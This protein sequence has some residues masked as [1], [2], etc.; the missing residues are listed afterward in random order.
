MSKFS[1]LNGIYMSGRVYDIFISYSR[2]DKWL[3]ADIC[4]SLRQAGLTVAFDED[5]LGNGD[6][7]GLSVLNIIESAKCVLFLC[8]PNSVQSNWVKNEINYCVG[9]GKRVVPV[10]LDRTELPVD[11]MSLLGALN[12]IPLNTDNLESDIAWLVNLV[13][14]F[15]KLI[16]CIHIMH[17]IRQKAFA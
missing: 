17:T 15:Q 8:T 13:R 9:I 12:V 16:Y 2:E 3:A 11:L 1:G 5:C 6:D 4:H 10:N 7:L 14:G